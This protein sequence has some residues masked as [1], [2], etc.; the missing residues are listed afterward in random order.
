MVNGESLVSRGGNGREYEVG[1]LALVP[2]IV[3]SSRRHFREAGL[4]GSRLESLHQLERRVRKGDV[5]VHLVQ[6]VNEPHQV[7]AFKVLLTL[8]VL[9]L[10]KYIME[11]IVKVG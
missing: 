11:L 4:E 3:L 7:F 10:V 5:A 6:V 2:H 1:S 9:L 8:R